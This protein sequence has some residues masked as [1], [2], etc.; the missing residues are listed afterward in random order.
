MDRAAFLRSLNFLRPLP[1]G[2]WDSCLD[3]NN[4]E[5]DPY[6]GSTITP[7][8]PSKTN[9]SIM[10]FEESLFVVSI[11]PKLRLSDGRKSGVAENNGG[12]IAFGRKRGRGDDAPAKLEGSTISFGPAF[13]Q[14]HSST[15]TKN[16][17]A[18]CDKATDAVETADATAQ[19]QDADMDG[20]HDTI[21]QDDVDAEE[22]DLKYQINSD[23]S[24]CTFEAVLM[25]KLPSALGDGEPVQDEGVFAT[26]TGHRQGTGHDVNEVESKALIF[27]FGNRFAFQVDESAILELKYEPGHNE[28]VSGDTEGGETNSKEI[29]KESPPSKKQ[30][31]EGGDPLPSDKTGIATKKLPPSLLI[32]F[33]SCTLRVFSL[34]DTNYGSDNTADTTRPSSRIWGTLA[35]TAETVENCLMNTRSVLLQQFDIGNKERKH[36]QSGAPSAWKLAPP[37][38]GL[39]FHSWPESIDNSSFHSNTLKYQAPSFLE[40]DWPCCL[41][42]KRTIE[43]PSA[44]SSPQKSS[45]PSKSGSSGTHF[46]HGQKEPSP[47]KNRS[48]QSHSATAENGDIGKNDNDEKNDAANH[49]S[50]LTHEFQQNEEDDGDKMIESQ[51]SF[52][53]EPR[54]NASD[55][56]EKNNDSD[57]ENNSKQSDKN[58]SNQLGDHKEKA[59]KDEMDMENTN[60]NQKSWKNGIYSKYHAFDESAIHMEK[61]MDAAS[62]SSQRQKSEADMSSLTLCAESLSSSY[63]PVNEFMSASQRCENEIE[64]TTSEMDI[65]LEKM[66]PARGRKSNAITS[67]QSEGFQKRIEELMSLRKEAVAAKLALLMIP[68]R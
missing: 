57:M 62:V 7:P 6:S 60:T 19:V 4:A 68:K 61:A 18:T 50:E 47:G 67:D 5:D 32:S 8:T 2:V 52:F 58:G 42:T 54:R 41:G 56:E 9:N 15:V 44:A 1:P 48:S 26:P 21:Q 13:F 25:K 22:T 31:H 64:N 35:K 65:A 53:E 45:S 55:L 12:D 28:G 43:C 66:F 24:L 59:G 16:S 51:S 33:S 40:E 11:E 63:L 14:D 29:G 3:G 39:A 17:E 10:L 34:E 27:R 30:R 23:A 46:E 20:D 37:G 38:S 49:S 36:Y